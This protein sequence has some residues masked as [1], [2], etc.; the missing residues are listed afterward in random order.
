MRTQ[1]G[2][3]TA[4]RPVPLRPSVWCVLLALLVAVA[5][6]ACSDDGGD[7]DDAG[8]GETS[9]TVPADTEAA[10]EPLA[11]LVTNDDGV[12]SEG[13]DVL[14]QGLAGLPDVTV[15]VVAPAENETGSSD[16]TTPSSVPV[17]D[18]A[19]ASGYEAVAVQGFPADSV[20]YAL[21]GLGLEPDLVVSGINEGQNIGDAVE[22]SGTVGAART[23][24]R[25]GL[26]ALAVSAG[27]AD[28]VDYETAVEL[29]LDWVEEHRDDLSPFEGQVVSINVPSCTE[30]E[31]RGVVEVPVGSGLGLEVAPDCTS[32][33]TEPVDD[34]EAF[35]N[36]YASLSEVGTGDG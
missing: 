13:I 16:T 5:A 3:R 30:G 15:T 6:V 34:V 32:A 36:G 35:A 14:V 11:I 31:V 24:A 33:L 28:L 25:R 27:L 20:I 1:L 2:T 26:P 18:T 4:R 29:A 19:T 9:T 10:A 12:G 17:E 8:S 23:A 7:D 21:D 22:L